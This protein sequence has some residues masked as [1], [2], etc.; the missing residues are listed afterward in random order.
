MLG[1]KDQVKR[2]KFIFLLKKSRHV[3]YIQVSF[4]K[5]AQFY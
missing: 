5:A 2:I 1:R 4:P 3:G